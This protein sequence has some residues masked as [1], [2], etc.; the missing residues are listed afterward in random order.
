MTSDDLKLAFGSQLRFVVSED[1]DIERAIRK[2]Y[3][4]QV[5]FVD[6]GD[7]PTFGPIEPQLDEIADDDWDQS[8]ASPA[9][10][11]VNAALAQAIEEG[12]SDVHFEPGERELV[13]RARIDGVMRELMRIPKTIQAGVTSRLKVLGELDIAERRV[14]QDGRFAVRF[15]GRPVDLR[16]AVM[17]T[18]HGEQVVLRMLHRAVSLSA[19]S[20]SEWRPTPKSRSCAASGSRTA[21]SS[22]ADRPA[23]ARRR[24]ST[25]RS[26]CSTRRSAC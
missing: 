24:L 15:G 23:A 2:V 25:A 6:Q 21:R 4:N 11:I 5:E 13:V 22:S 16:I 7:H 3:R 8:E 12:A 17:P 9:V 26:T 18:T 10:K 19:S 1:E 20:S 14:P